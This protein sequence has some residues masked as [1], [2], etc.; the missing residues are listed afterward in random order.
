MANR[1]LDVTYDPI[2]DKLYAA[3][4]IKGIDR[5]LLTPSSKT[6][7]SGTY[8]LSVDDAESLILFDTVDVVVTLTSGSYRVGSKISLLSGDSNE[9]TLVGSGVTLYSTISNTSTA[10]TYRNNFSNANINLTCIG[11]DKWIVE[12]G[13]T[14]DEQK[15]YTVTVDSGNY[16]FNGSGL[17]NAA[18]PSLTLTVGQFLMVDNQSGSSHPFVVKKGNVSG[19]ATGAGP[20]SPGWARLENNNQHG[21]DN[22]LQVSFKESGDYYY[23]C[24]AH[25]SMKG[26]ITVS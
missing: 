24:Q 5:V 25:S 26:S 15:S 2:D 1:S 16:V 12:G 17:T 19:A 7:T 11:T 21:S 10:N 18:N 9:V 4:K 8:T 13:V 22:K 14:A 3:R 20:T 23:I 6:V